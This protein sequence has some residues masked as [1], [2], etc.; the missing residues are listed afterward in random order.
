MRLKSKFARLAGAG[1][2]AISAYLS[3]ISADGAYAQA[4]NLP[5]QNG[6]IFIPPQGEPFKG[7]TEKGRLE[8]G[9][10]DRR[11]RLELQERLQRE[12]AGTH[13][14]VV[15]AA[16]NYYGFGA[17][18]TDLATRMRD[19]PGVF[20][21]EALS[22]MSQVAREMA[23]LMPERN[24]AEKAERAKMI[25]LIGDLER[26]AAG[27][28][29]DQMKAQGTSSLM[30]VDTNDVEVRKILVRSYL[31]GAWM[32]APAQKMPRTEALTNLKQRDALAHL[33]YINRTSYPYARVEGRVPVPDAPKRAY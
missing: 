5:P 24:D 29:H 11:K 30:R 26:D 3:S 19:L 32:D 10:Q 13:A 22:A 31:L 20:T 16:K 6:K 21:G 9:V 17:Q 23:R 1:F 12:R 4:P 25:K 15:I 8:Y 27:V 33:T 18:P 14:P 7:Y 2:I 28:G